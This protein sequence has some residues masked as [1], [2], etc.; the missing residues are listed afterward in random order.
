MKP[1]TPE[2]VESAIDATKWAQILTLV[3]EN[4]LFTA[5]VLFCLWQSGALLSAYSTAGGA[6]CG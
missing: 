6:I 1:V 2:T 5:L 4:Q 3:K